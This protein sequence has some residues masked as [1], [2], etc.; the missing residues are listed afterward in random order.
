MVRD[1]DSLEG[2]VYQRAPFL[3]DMLYSIKQSIFYII[4]SGGAKTDKGPLPPNSG[5]A[6][7]GQGGRLPPT[8]LFQLLVGNLSENLSES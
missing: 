3:D 2:G 7:G 6:R 8:N 1:A 4:L 5:V